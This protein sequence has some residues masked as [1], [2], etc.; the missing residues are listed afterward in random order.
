MS[1]VL[2]Q[3]RAPLGP[4]LEAG[5]SLNAASCF[6]LTSRHS[7]NNHF[8]AAASSRPIA[9]HFRLRPPRALFKMAAKTDANCIFCKIIAGRSRRSSCTIPR[10]RMLS[11]VGSHLQITIGAAI[12]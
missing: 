4:H 9:H 11:S 10:R 5:E 8:A 3:K 7:S 1:C 12:E 6:T 2:H